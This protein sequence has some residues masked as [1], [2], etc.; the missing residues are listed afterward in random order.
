M[1]VCHTLFERLRGTSRCP[2]GWDIRA[3]TSCQSRRGFTGRDGARPS[4]PL[5]SAVE[6]RPPCRPQLNGFTLIE[7]LVVIAILGILS[8]ALVVSV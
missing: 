5:F 8:S 2:G 7:L 4:R 1:A 3:Q 6:G